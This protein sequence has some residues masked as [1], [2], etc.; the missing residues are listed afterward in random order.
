[1]IIDLLAVTH[2]STVHTTGRTTSDV[3]QQFARLTGVSPTFRRS[4]TGERDNVSELTA[5]SEPE[6]SSEQ[7]PIVVRLFPAIRDDEG[8]LRL[9]LSR[10]ASALSREGPLGVSDK[11]IDVAIALEVMYQAGSELRYKLATRASYFLE[12]NAGDRQA[13]YDTISA[14]YDLRSS[15]VHGRRRLRQ[16]EE[17]VVKGGFDI[18]RRTLSKLALEGGPSTDKNWDKLVIEGGG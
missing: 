18:A 16:D 3:D 10:L 15:T 4:V 11:T 17:G 8:K 13:T 1:M 9:A 12:D 14:L 6:V 7:F 5:P 2:T